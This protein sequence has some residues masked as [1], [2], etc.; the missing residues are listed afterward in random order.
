MFDPRSLVPRDKHD[1]A[2]L[3]GLESAGYPA[4]APILDDLL[5]W[6][7]DGNWPI[8][9]HLARFLV[10]LGIPI[11]DSVSRVLRGDDASRKYFC[12]ELI[13]ENLSIDVLEALGDD[14]IKLADQPSMTDLLEGV[15]ELAREAL[16]RLR[17]SA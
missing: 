1:I 4:I 16:L 12:F 17:Y 14:L 11:V 8:A 9:P 3:S 5:A 15:D 6:T 13:V 7:A 10:T 2:A